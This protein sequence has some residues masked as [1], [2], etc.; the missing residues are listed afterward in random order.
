MTRGA[1]VL[2]DDITV[3]IDAEPGEPVND[4]VNR[5]LGRPLPVRVL[6]PSIRN[7]I[8]PLR[9]R[10]YSQLNSAVRAPPICRKPV[11]DGAKRVTTVSAIDSS[12]PRPGTEQ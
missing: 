9:P 3:P 12:S 8:F 10:A 6:D 4:C 11:G 2:I 7:S 1:S 5:S